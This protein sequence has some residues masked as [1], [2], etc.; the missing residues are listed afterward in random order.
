VSTDARSVYFHDVAT[1]LQTPMLTHDW[2]VLTDFLNS[3]SGT[4]GH[5][6]LKT[7]LEITYQD[8]FFYLTKQNK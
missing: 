8:P 5:K 2:V 1:Y 4:L 3:F 7:A 6:A